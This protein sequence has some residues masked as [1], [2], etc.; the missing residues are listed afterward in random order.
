MSVL[1]NNLEMMTGALLPDLIWNDVVKSGNDPLLD[2][3]PFGYVDA[4]KIKYDMY[5][6][7][8]GLVPLRGLDHAPDYVQ[9]PGFRSYQIDPGYFGLA[10][11]LRESEITSE[12]QPGTLA[13]PLDVSD[14]LSKLM[15]DSASMLVSRFRKCVGDLLATGTLTVTGT[16]GQVFQYQ[17]ANYRTLSPGTGWQAAPTT[18]TP[19]TDLMGWQAT[20][21]KG[22]S[23]EFGPDSVLLCNSN[24]IVDIFKTTQVQSTYRGPYGSSIIGVDDTADLTGLNKILQGF[25]LPAI[26]RYDKGYFPTLDDAKAQN[27]ANWNYIIP[28]K[29]LIWI[30]KRPGSQQ[31][32]QF[33]LTRHAGLVG[34]N[35]ADRY[36]SI[37]VR[38]EN[39][40]E[41][42]KG[43]YVRAHYH[44]RMPHHCDLE[45]GWNGCP[46]LWYS[47]AA[48]GISYS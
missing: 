14:R 10:T 42:A 12:R 7:P 48:A 30:G 47:T 4:D 26:V 28:N 3:L 15:L 44:N 29:T 33:Q 20:L 37:D 6:D 18:A 21:Q 24:T 43:M 45:A 27:F 1:A 39:A 17:A 2:A 35:G 34:V 16:A 8:Y 40:A 11:Q 25:G 38:D 32:G 9:M 13:D 41:V 23:S 19:L 46:V 31:I 36:P 22:S 5:E